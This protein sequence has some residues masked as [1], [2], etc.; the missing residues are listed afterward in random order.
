MGPKERITSSILSAALNA[1]KTESLDASR[2]PRNS[3]LSDVSTARRIFRRRAFPCSFRAPVRR[4]AQ[5]LPGQC[6]E[7]I[8]RKILPAARYVLSNQAHE[9]VRDEVNPAEQESKQTTQSEIK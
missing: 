7:E 8:R 3:I 4:L 5:S 2:N 6:L 1:A 9:R